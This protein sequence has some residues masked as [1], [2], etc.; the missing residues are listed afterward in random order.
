MR[1][2]EPVEGIFKLEVPFEDIYTAVFAVS[3]AD[4]DRYALIDAATTSHDVNA[5]ILPAL[6]EIGFKKS[7]PEMLLL[8]HRHGDHAGGAARLRELFPSMPVYSPEPLKACPV[9]SLAGGEVFLG[10]Y[11][12]ILLP[13]HTGSSVGYL[14]RVSGTLL[15]GDCLQLWGVS[16]YTDNIAY[17]DRYLASIKHLRR[18]KPGRILA[19]HEYVPLGSIAEGENAVMQ[20]LDECER[21]CLHMKSKGEKL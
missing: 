6:R 8:T 1:I 13:G 19:S 15:S 9:T 18:L 3:D 10:R 17:P 12:A 2:T 16:R 21:A 7:A 11:E 5:F 14:D 4:G 20:Y